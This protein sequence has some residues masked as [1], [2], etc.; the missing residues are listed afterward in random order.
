MLAFPKLK[1]SLFKNATV[2]TSEDAGVL[3]NTDVLV[4]EGK[5]ASIGKDLNSGGAKTIDATGKHLTAGIIDEHSHIAALAIN[6][7]GQNSTAEVKMT[8]VVDNEDIG[9]YYA[10]AG[11]G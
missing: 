5:I 11:W 6:E 8:D 10:L 1:K 9:I 7:A 2:W 3:L 4:S